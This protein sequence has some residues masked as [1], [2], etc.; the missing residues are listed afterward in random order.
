MEGQIPG[1][2]ED[3]SVEQPKTIFGYGFEQRLGHSDF[4]NV[5]LIGGVC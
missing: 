4:F 5:S 3:A 1:L 2:W